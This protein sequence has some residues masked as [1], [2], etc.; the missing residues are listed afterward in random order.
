MSESSKLLELVA[1]HGMEMTLPGDTP[2]LEAIATKNWTRP[3]NVFSS[4]N[5][6]DKVVYCTTEPRLRG[7]GTDHMLILTVIELPIEQVQVVPSY[8]FREAEWDDF[9]NK[10]EA[11]LVDIP[12]LAMLLTEADFSEVVKNLTGIIQDT[13]RTTVPQM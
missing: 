1:D 10:L 7:P 9:R 12:S 4:S 2:T 3:D 8:N 5:L 11:R 6:A 13:I